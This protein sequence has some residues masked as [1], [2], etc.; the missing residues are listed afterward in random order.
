MAFL[1]PRIVVAG[2]VIIAIIF[3]Y[4][5]SRGSSVDASSD[6]RDIIT[7]QR[8]ALHVLN[9]SGVA[10]FAPLDVNSGRWLNLTGLR[11]DDGYAWT[12]LQTAKDAARLDVERF[13]G[14][15]GT[16]ILD[17]VSNDTLPLYQNVSGWVLGQWCSVE[18]PEGFQF[19]I[20]NLSAVAPNVSYS[21]TW[22][23]NI[24]G[25]GGKVQL[26]LK[27]EEEDDDH[28]VHLKSNMAYMSARLTIQDDHSRGDGWEMTLHGVH[29]KASGHCVLTTTSEKFVRALQ[30]FQF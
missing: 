11:K 15:R 29:H 2:V 8:T 19:P 4:P 23:R 6:T 18:P 13:T 28:G 17:N 16:E 30:C 25:V 22:E 9:A 14:H 21:D 20:V 26:K 3:F 12:L 5:S 10:D 7:R 27:D 1:S 24:T